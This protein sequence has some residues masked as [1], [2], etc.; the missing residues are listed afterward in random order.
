M[1]TAYMTHFKL[2]AIILSDCFLLFREKSLK[3]NPKRPQKQ[4][5]SHQN[6]TKTNIITLKDHKKKQTQVHQ[7]T[8]NNKKRYPCLHAFKKR[9]YK[10]KLK[11]RA[12]RNEIK[13]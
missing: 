2:N 11:K 9:L 10:T 13:L 1:S 4:I 6:T 12:I 8:T 5:Q 3:L 7:N